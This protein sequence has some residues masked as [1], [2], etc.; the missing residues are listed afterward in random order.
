LNSTEQKQTTD[1]N[2]SITEA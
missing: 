2:M 1:S